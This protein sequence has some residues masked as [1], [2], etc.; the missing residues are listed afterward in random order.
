MPCFGRECRNSSKCASV[1]V[2]VKRFNFLL[3]WPINTWP[4]VSAVEQFNY[5]RCHWVE[6]CVV[7][8]F[9]FITRCSKWCLEQI[10]PTPVQSHSTSTDT[11]DHLECISIKLCM[12]LVH[13]YFTPLLL[14][15]LGQACGHTAMV[16]TTWG[17]VRGRGITA[18]WPN[19]VIL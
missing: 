14:T 19:M 3:T 7:K 18:L 13:A 11:T 8:Q 16:L 17:W 5:S 1:G 10:Q 6:R 12:W 2:S 4:C 15:P 9:D